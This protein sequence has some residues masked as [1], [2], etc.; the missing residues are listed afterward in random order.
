MSFYFLLIFTDKND[1]WDKAIAIWPEHKIW[2]VSSS[3]RDVTTNKDE[4]AL[5]TSY[6]AKS[7][8]NAF[9]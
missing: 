3:S 9:F 7:K 4:I 6:K 8:Q 2:A 1:D 5:E